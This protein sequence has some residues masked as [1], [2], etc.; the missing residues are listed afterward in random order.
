MLITH[1][2]PEGVGRGGSGHGDDV[3]CPHLS[4]VVNKIKSVAHDHTVSSLPLNTF[5]PAVHVF[6]HVHSGY[7]VTQTA[8]L[9]PTSVFRI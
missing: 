9:P 7:G 3:G 2:P 6:G 1:G 5:R 8:G 4:Q